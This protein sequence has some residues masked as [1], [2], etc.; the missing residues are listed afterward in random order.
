[1]DSTSGVSSMD[2]LVNR[3]AMI[4]DNLTGGLNKA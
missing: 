4:D 3:S 1:M 2:I